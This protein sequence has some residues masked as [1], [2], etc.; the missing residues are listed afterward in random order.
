MARMELEDRHQIDNLLDGL[1]PATG[2]VAPHN[3]GFFWQDPHSQYPYSTSKAW[4]YQTLGF[5]MGSSVRSQTVRLTR[6]ITLGINTSPD[7]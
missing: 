2:M 7:P 1:A 3:S 4:R 6:M 5:S